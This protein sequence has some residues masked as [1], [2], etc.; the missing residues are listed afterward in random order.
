MNTKPG[1]H[2][3]DS[4][5]EGLIPTMNNTG[6]MTEK[7]DSYSADFA[8]YAGT[9]DGE[10]LDIGCAYGIATLAALEN[11]ARV[12]AC[13]MDPRH[14]EVLYARVPEQL[15]GR[16]RSKAATMPAVDFPQGS[17]AA[18]LAARVLHFLNGTDIEVTVRKMKDWLIPGGR[19]YL[20]ADSPYTGPWAPQAGEY[21]RRKSEGDAWPGYVAD[22]A[23]FLP[24]HVD[25][26]EHPDF[27]NP[28][29]PDILKRV[30]TNAGLEVIA[31]SFLSSA[32]KH[33]NGRDHAGVIA[34]KASRG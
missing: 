28:L 11:G 14:L 3:P 8:E 9:A 17:F 6:W 1:P 18:I 19:L 13:D 7:M 22:Y 16:Y 4:P 12:L 5:V 23:S 2:L 20:V 31:A 21:E 32:T 26:A 30:C 34:L 15:R 29:D 33:A 24:A 27:I 10:V 25:P